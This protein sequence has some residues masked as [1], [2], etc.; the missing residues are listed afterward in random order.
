MKE[1]IQ[2][3]LELYQAMEYCGTHPKQIYEYERSHR[4]TKSKFEKWW[5]DQCYCEARILWREATGETEKHC[6]LQRGF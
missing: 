4:L 5:W 1:I 3:A 2:K 6:I